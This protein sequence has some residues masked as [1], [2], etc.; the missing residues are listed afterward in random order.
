MHDEPAASP[1]K[2]TL[3]DLFVTLLVVGGTLAI[4]AAF[5]LPVTRRGTSETA[6]R[7]QC[8]NNLKQLALACHSFHD[9]NQAL[10][11]ARLDERR[12]RGLSGADPNDMTALGPNWMVLA[13]PYYEASTSEESFPASDAPAW[14]PMTGIKSGF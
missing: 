14:T 11:A 1:S 8:S 5:L 13:S 6:R 9:V 12:E 2:F 4:L 7:I 3:T 10:P